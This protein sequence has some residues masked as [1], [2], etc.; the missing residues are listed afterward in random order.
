TKFYDENGEAIELNPGNTW[1]EVVPPDR[2][3]EY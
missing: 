3:I 2:G 1:V